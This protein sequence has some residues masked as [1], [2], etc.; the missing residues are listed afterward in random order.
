MKKFDNEGLGL[1]LN[2]VLFS[3]LLLVLVIALSFP[4]FSVE[5]KMKCY[6][7]GM[8]E[9]EKPDYYK[10]TKNILG[11]QKF[12]VR[13]RNEWIPYCK[14]TDKNLFSRYKAFEGK[15]KFL[16][17]EVGDKAIECIYLQSEKDSQTDESVI[18]ENKLLIDFDLNFTKYSYRREKDS[19]FK[20]SN[21]RKASKCEV[22]K[23]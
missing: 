20:I 8:P 9:H 11:K 2:K 6:K 14:V 19:E 16:S 17:Q 18:W 4:F 10:Y 7:W 1:S 5:K 22:I 3:I 12:F 15:T 21:G 23:D 13:E